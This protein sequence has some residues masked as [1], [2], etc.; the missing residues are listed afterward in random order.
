MKSAFEERYKKLNEAQKRAVDTIEGP[1]LVVA[2]PGSGKT[3]LLSLRVANILRLGN[4]GPQNI[5]CLTF[6]DNAAL[7]MRER[8]VQ[9]IGTDAYRVGIFT[10]HAFCSHIISRFPEYFY[11]A[12]TFTNIPDVVRAEILE[13]IFSALPHK[14]PLASYHPETGYAYL[15]DAKERI[16]HIKNGGYRPDE[17]R[18]ALELVLSDYEEVHAALSSWPD[19]MRIKTSIA[20]VQVVQKKLQA[21]PEN[22][23]ARAL[24]STLAPALE[25]ALEENKTATLTK[26]QNLYTVKDVSGR[27]LKDYAKV[28]LMRAMADVY[29]SYTKALHTRGYYDYDDMIIDVSHA[30]REHDVLRAEIEEQYQY[31][32]VDEFQDTN[33]A[34][35]GVVRAITSNPVYEGK[36]NVCV[37][38]DDDQAIYKFQGAEVSHMMHFR[39]VLYKD[40]KT[41]VLDKNYRS[42]QDILFLARNVV[43]Q[44]NIRLENKYKD[45]TKVLSSENKS[46]PKGEVEIASCPSDLEEYNAVVQS[47]RKALDNGEHPE[48]IAIIA[49]EHKQLQAILPFL[50]SAHV[51][52]SYTKKANAF[53]E[54]HIKELVII[55]EYLSSGLSYEGSRNDL[56][57]QIL[58]FSFWGISRVSLF[59]VAETV[60][61]E[62]VSW[63]KACASSEDEKIKKSLEL[64]TGLSIES[65]STPLEHILER[66]MKESG[67]KDYYFSDIVRKNRPQEYIHFLAALK[68]FIDALREHKEGEVLT[69]KDVTPFVETH[70]THNIPLVVHSLYTQGEHAVSLHTAHSSKGLEFGRV[71]IINAHEDSWAKPS[72]RKNKI[73]LP[74]VLNTLL[75]PAGDDEDDFIRLL[76]VAITRAKHSL[77]ISSHKPQVRY[78]ESGHV[79]ENN[80]EEREVLGEEDIVALHEQMLSLVQAPY[81]GDEQT[82]FK[83]LLESYQMPVTHLTNFLNVTEGGP[84]FFLERNLLRFPE[85]LNPSGAYG[86]AIHKAIEEIISYPRFYGGEKPTLEHI[87][88][89]FD[90]SLSKARLPKEDDVHQRDRGH[91]L[92]TRYYKERSAFFVHTDQVE[93]DMKNEGVVVERAHLTGKLDFLRV[94]SGRLQVRDFK[95]GKAFSSWDRAK[96][97]HE[98]IKLH[99]QKMQLIFYKILLENSNR[100]KESAVDSLTL[101][102]VE[103]DDSEKIVELSLEPEVQ[104]VERVKKLIGIVYKKI[105]ALDFPNIEGYSKDYKGIIAFEEDLLTGKI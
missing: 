6:T 40:V 20:E 98:K 85:P 24:L 71:Y 37:V 53:D 10:F 16:K 4:V 27:I 82:I 67:F 97:D 28:D 72:K 51:P 52:Y 64:L 74:L 77:H 80:N 61:K 91:A 15:Y 3:E 29:D 42:T 41:I 57:P 90:Q 86:S 1:V 21:F 95:T 94:E 70:R 78:L 12:A 87:I 47:I 104:D 18:A 83:R 46:L 60:K 66:F 56:L 11:N 58:S 7:N 88:G 99:N 75:T 34:Q 31:V 92:L 93:V 105:I 17:F 96:G 26:W 36:S 25:K 30:L 79:L 14:H 35:M 13:S 84:Q 22:V 32:L 59:L 48:E 103:G 63:V 45:I 44:G 62:H 68:T 76:Y 69:T 73:P 65:V 33:E 89:V 8:L 43:V 39:D 23:T 102:Y 55:C 54:E 2:G 100:F 81:T 9:L 49:R 5:L 50:D 38:G 19:N 101:E